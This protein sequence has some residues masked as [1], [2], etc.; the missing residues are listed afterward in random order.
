[1]RFGFVSSF[2]TPEQHVALARECEEHGW[3]GFFFWDGVDLGDWGG[4]GVATWDPFSILTAAARVTERIT[5]GALVFAFPRHRPWELAQRVLT[6]DHLSGG[7]LVLPVGLG[8]LDDH[9]FKSVAEQEKGLRE[10]AELLD[11]MLA[12]LAESWSGER[13]AFD[14]THLHTGDFRFPVAP[15]NGRV[16]V[17]PVAAWPSE[18]SM[19]RAARWDGVV[20]QLRSTTTTAAETPLGAQDVA[21]LVAWARERRAAAGT[22]APWDVVT[23]GIL[24]DDP[25]EAAAH[26]SALAEAGATWWVESRWDPATATPESLLERVRQGP[27]AL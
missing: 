19:S 21:D 11:D 13:F 3:D 22:E 8:V 15:V 24:P 26:A 25:G 7:R 18:K 16:P 14:G 27:P 4:G 6:V 1:M 17:W 20:P 12:Y 5:L 9:A 23:Q 10:R 2:G